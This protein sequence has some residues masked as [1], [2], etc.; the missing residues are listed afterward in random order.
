MMTAPRDDFLFDAV[1]PA[2]RVALFD[3]IRDELCSRAIGV[4]PDIVR[5]LALIGTQHLAGDAGARVLFRGPGGAGKSFLARTLAEI[6]DLPVLLINSGLI[7]EMN[8]SGFDIADAVAGCWVRFEGSIHR[9]RRISLLEPSS[10][11]R[12]SIKPVSAVVG[13]PPVAPSITGLESRT[14]SF[15]W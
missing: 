14:G 9:R 4:A 7:A 13:A 1:T 5:R 10:S 8:W 2:D 3:L 15:R 11:S 12:T 6:L